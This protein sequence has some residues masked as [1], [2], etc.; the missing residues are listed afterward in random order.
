MEWV[1]LIILCT[2][3]YINRKRFIVF[4]IGVFSFL[5]F[6]FWLGLFIT[7]TAYYYYF[8]EEERLNE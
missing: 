2:L 4:L 7:I 3:L 8:T 6:G 1:I 5:V